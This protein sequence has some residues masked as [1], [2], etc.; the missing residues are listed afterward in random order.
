[1]KAYYEYEDGTFWAIHT[2]GKNYYTAKGRKYDGL[3]PESMQKAK[4]EEAYLYKVKRIP[5]ESSEA[6]EQEALLWAA[7]KSVS[8]IRQDAE[9]WRIAIEINALLLFFVPDEYKT[10]E[11]CT[12]AVAR[13][14]MALKHVPP[15]M[16]IPELCKRAVYNDTRT[17]EFVGE[18]E[19]TKELCLMAVKNHGSALEYVPY[20]LRTAEICL[21]AV[22][23][24]GSALEYVPEALKTQELCLAALK[25]DFSEWTMRYIPE[26]VRTS[27][28]YE[29]CL[30]SADRYS[31]LHRIIPPEPL[32]EEVYRKAVRNNSD[33]LAAVP[34]EQR[35]YELC[36]EALLNDHSIGSPLEYVPDKFKTPEF[37]LNCVRIKGRYL[38]DVPEALKSYELC[39]EA[40]RE[41]GYALE[42]APPHLLTGEIIL[43]A[44]C[45]NS[46]AL[47]YVP[48]AFQTD[49]VYIE[50]IK[51]DDFGFALGY[52]P[53]KYH[54]SE[55]CLAMLSKPNDDHHISL[56]RI[57][58]S[59]ITEDFLLAA[60]RLNGEML[61]Y[62]PKKLRT[63][64][65]CFEAVKNNGWAL[66]FTPR[67]YI[68]E[69]LCNTAV[70]KM[71]ALLNLCLTISSQAICAARL[72]NKT[73]GQ[74]IT[75]LN[76]TA[77]RSSGALRYPN[78]AMP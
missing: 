6:A 39:L 76:S 18:N 29:K 9:F 33:A 71:E 34:M 78:A 54:T 22:K 62:V 61:K 59:V 23:H 75:F 32:S 30:L 65:L 35:T 52:V 53:E 7:E 27:D 8:A 66:E 4:S 26:N 67:P 49:E 37:C 50:A 69:T 10:Q 20:Q 57:P 13:D 41:N 3:D 12:L 70:Q 15:E 56:G 45:Q 1:M 40:V 48:A 16:R 14:G 28:F 60:T 73:D 36:V 11:L 44:V 42:Y 24:Y 2:E 77:P 43:A 47:Q 31:S 63:Q 38:E 64:E 72:W 25:N 55:N 46:D 5:C 19:K 68:T 58:K 51:N 74:L 17:L 21:E